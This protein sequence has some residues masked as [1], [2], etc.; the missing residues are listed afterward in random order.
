MLQAG[1]NYN[2][3]IGTGDPTPVSVEPAQE[4]KES[5]VHRH[6]LL[7]GTI[8]LSGLIVLGGA[9]VLQRMGVTPAPQSGSWG[10]AG[11]AFFS[12]V[13]NATPVRPASGSAPTTPT[14]DYAVIPIFDTTISEDTTEVPE[15]LNELLALLVQPKTDVDINAPETPDAYS[16]IPQGLVSAEKPEKPRTQT[17]NSLHSFG[18]AVGTLVKP[19]EESARI[20]AQTLKNHAEDRSDPEKMAQ[21]EAL[22][23]TLAQLG[24]DI[25]GIADIPESARAAHKEYGTAY[26]ILGTQL[27]ALSK[28]KTDEEFLS[29]IVDYNTAVEELTKK[30]LMLVAIFN[31]N[32]VTFSSSDPGSIFMFSGT[33]GL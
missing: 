26:R 22:A 29:A 13:R 10:G 30:F 8:A 18:N 9:I 17:Q 7:A 11:G 20:N 1:G 16:F 6:P 3:M 5:W 2:D 19:F 14:E 12:T 25:L 21:V 33:A 32:N 27:A 24:V 15:G 28:A 23:F 4:A 31:A